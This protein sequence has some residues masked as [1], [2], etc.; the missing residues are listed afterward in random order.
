MPSHW[1]QRSGR[2]FTRHSAVEMPCLSV[3]G[4]PFMLTR[5]AEGP[6]HCQEDRRGRLPAQAENTGCEPAPTWA[7]NMHASLLSWVWLLPNC[8]FSP[9]TCSQ[10]LPGPHTFSSMSHSHSG[11]THTHNTRLTHIHRHTRNVHRETHSENTHAQHA[12]P[13]N[14]R[15]HAQK[16]QE[17]H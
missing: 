12:H 13:G 16:H 17:T 3:A 4:P 15:T 1:N 14:T 10:A 2:Q 11:S 7:P 8:Y 9:A 6:L 5:R